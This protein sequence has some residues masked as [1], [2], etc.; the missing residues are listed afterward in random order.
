MANVLG[1]R[2]VLLELAQKDVAMKPVDLLHIA[3]YY[4]LASLEALGHATATTT[5][6]GSRLLEETPNARLQVLNVSSLG[7]QKLGHN[8]SVKKKHF[9]DQV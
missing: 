4:R 3:K 5:L 8:K 7:L 2:L 9:N 6:G 1:H